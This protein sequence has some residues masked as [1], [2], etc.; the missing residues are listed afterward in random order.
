MSKKVL[1]N[2]EI[3][4]KQQKQF[5]IGL[6][7]GFLLF[8]VFIIFM[9]SDFLRN[10]KVVDSSLLKAP[11]VINIDNK[12]QKGL[13]MQKVIS[14]Y[15]VF[16]EEVNG[17]SLNTIKDQEFL[18]KGDYYEFVNENY[19]YY[20][21]TGYLRLT[22]KDQDVYINSFEEGI[23]KIELFGNSHYILEYSASTISFTKDNNSYL[24]SIM[25][26]KY[27]LDCNYEISGYKNEEEIYDSNW[28]FINI[29][30]SKENNNYVGY[31]FDNLD[32]YSLSEDKAEIVNSNNERV[33]STKYDS[34]TG[35][36]YYTVLTYSFN[37]SMQKDLL[38]VN[39]NMEFP[40]K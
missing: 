38:I 25:D 23:T 16:I 14:D 24:I 10:K 19:T 15:E 12:E 40:L 22:R 36:I 17:L 39:K 1:N 21:N 18:K 11:D 7:L 4:K 34:E 5:S 13:E 27:I 30:L 9:E 29:T 33:P 8:I 20:M 26:N 2:E 28:N 6:C 37:E 3:Q 31:F 35:D 32:E